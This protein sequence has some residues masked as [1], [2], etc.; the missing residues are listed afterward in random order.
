MIAALPTEN[1]FKKYVKKKTV[2]LDMYR[3]TALF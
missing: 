2:I 3:I 1:T